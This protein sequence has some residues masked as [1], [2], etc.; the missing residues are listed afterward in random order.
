MPAVDWAM[1]PNTTYDQAAGARALFTANAQGL[2]DRTIIPAPL[3]L[4]GLS[5]F[6]Y[7][8]SG[9]DLYF[10]TAY[11]TCQGWTSSADT[12][13]GDCAEAGAAELFTASLPETC[14][15]CSRRSHCVSQ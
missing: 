3:F 9:L 11:R 4:S 5:T 7:L 1:K 13:Q 15:Y 8:W 12:E 14:A 10:T 2:Y 6:V